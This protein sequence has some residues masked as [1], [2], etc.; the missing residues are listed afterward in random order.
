VPP[1]LDE[2]LYTSMTIRKD[3]KT[4]ALWRFLDLVLAAYA[5]SCDVDAGVASFA[6]LAALAVA[7]RL[8]LSEQAVGMMRDSA[9]AT[10]RRRGP[11][12]GE[13]S[14]SDVDA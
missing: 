10:A 7:E 9:V 2:E 5:V 14:R 6:M 11:R 1:S 13:P 4:Q 12:R 8:A 3:R